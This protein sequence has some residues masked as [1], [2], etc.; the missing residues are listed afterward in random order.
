MPPLASDWRSEITRR[1]EIAPTITAMQRYLLFGRRC[2][3]IEESNPAPGDHRMVVTLHEATW[4]GRGATA[5]EAMGRAIL[6]LPE[7]TEAET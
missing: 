5:D 1:L 7:L 4:K 2:S 3:A 6:A